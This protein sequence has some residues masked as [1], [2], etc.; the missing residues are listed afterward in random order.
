MLF[1]W[2]RRKEAANLVK[3]GVDFSGVPI[4][5]GDPKR[6]FIRHPEL[7][8]REVR[9]QFVGFDGRGVLTV[10]FTLRDGVM[11]IIGAGYWRKQKELYE[12]QD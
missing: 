2:D 1:E 9:W 6:L 7:T 3:H 10:R 5:F 12:N 8:S 11:R 4:A